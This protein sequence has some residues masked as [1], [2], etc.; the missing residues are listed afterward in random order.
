MQGISSWGA[1]WTSGAYHHDVHSSGADSES[2]FARSSEIQQATIIVEKQLEDPGIMTRFLIQIT[3]SHTKKQKA[4]YSYE[5]KWCCLSYP[6]DFSKNHLQFVLLM[7]AVRTVIK[8]HLKAKIKIM[9]MGLDEFLS[10]VELEAS[11]VV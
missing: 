8:W 4:C 10:K 3:T 11:C 7:D 9:V 1:L 5:E 2:A 6:Y